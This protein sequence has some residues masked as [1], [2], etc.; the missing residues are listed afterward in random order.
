MKRKKFDLSAFLKGVYSWAMQI[1]QCQYLSPFYTYYFLKLN[2]YKQKLLTKTI[3]TT[4]LKYAFNW[5]TL[6][7]IV[8]IGKAFKSKYF[9]CPN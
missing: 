3:V 9:P 5:L 2:V 1:F 6:I 7:P 4:K 8:I